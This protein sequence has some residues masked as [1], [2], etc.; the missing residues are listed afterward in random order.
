MRELCCYDVF[1][2]LR[3]V[4]GFWSSSWCSWLCIQCIIWGRGLGN[5]GIWNER[6]QVR[7]SSLF[8]LLWWYLSIHVLFCI[9]TILTDKCSSWVSPSQPHHV[10][11]FDSTAVLLFT[12]MRITRLVWKKWSKES[13][14]KMYLKK[15]W[16]KSW[17][18]WSIEPILMYS[19]WILRVVALEWT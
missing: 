5:W 18:V 2:K 4:S 15:Q 10:C 16:R 6:S 17:I 11:V 8:V 7:I 1:Y 9:S 13:L 3:C 14:V 12:L 19:V